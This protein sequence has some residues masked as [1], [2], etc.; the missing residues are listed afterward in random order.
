[1]SAMVKPAREIVE[2]VSDVVGYGMVSQMLSCISRP[3]D[4]DGVSLGEGWPH[5][6]GGLD[7]LVKNLTVDH[8]LPGD[9]ER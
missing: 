9:A 6:M 2:L 4:G 8:R 5:G 3:A 7:D 1:M